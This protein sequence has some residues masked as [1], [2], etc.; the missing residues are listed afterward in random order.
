MRAPVADGC[1][2]R[3][4]RRDDRVVDPSACEAETG[5]YV[6]PLEV[7]QF[8]ENLLT[9]QASRQ[10]VEHIGDAN[11]QPPYTRASAALSGIDGDAV[12]KNS[13]RAQPE[14]TAVP[15][16]EPAVGNDRPRSARSRSEEGLLHSV[17]VGDIPLKINDLGV[18]VDQT[19]VEPVT[20]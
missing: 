14:Y 3:G 19:G 2:A 6:F 17:T 5:G 1:R 20:S 16:R 10:E 7:G 11:A 13:H 18:L 12:S 4:S 15:V 8:L 9:S